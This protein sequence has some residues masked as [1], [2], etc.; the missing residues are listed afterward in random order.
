MRLQTRRAWRE[1][2]KALALLFLSSSHQVEFDC[3]KTCKTRL[4]D[5][6]IGQI[7]CGQPPRR[8]TGT[9]TDCR[10]R[11]NLLSTTT[12]WKCVGYVRST[13]HRLK[14]SGI[15]AH[16]DAFSST[17][18]ILSSRLWRAPTRTAHDCGVCVSFASDVAILQN[19]S[20]LLFNPKSDNV[21][22]R[23]TIW[24]LSRGPRVLLD[25]RMTIS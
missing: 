2:Q 9:C 14:I 23:E 7:R 20:Q 21:W 17:C 19:V 25:G 1:L 8:K 5:L 10:L 15:S 12:I 6:S 24:R 4:G 3:A 18:P 13:L 11:M 22:L 16:A